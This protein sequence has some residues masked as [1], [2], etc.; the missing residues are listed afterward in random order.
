MWASN[1][2]KLK[3]LYLEIEAGGGGGRCKDNR[4]FPVKKFTLNGSKFG[5]NV[6][7]ITALY[8]VAD[9]C[10]KVMLY[11]GCEVTKPCTKNNNNV[12]ALIKGNRVNFTLYILVNFRNKPPTPNN[13]ACPY[14]IRKWVM[15]G[16]II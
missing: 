8:G 12:V 16:N 15:I 2:L 4:N 6:I 3:S 5:N 9:I 11:L 1:L 13:N 10:S 7:K 14:I